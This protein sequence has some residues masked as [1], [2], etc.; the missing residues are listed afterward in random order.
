MNDHDPPTGPQF[1]ASRPTE[2]ESVRTTIVG[3]RPPGSGQ[4]LGNLCRGVEVLV[5]KASVDPAFKELLLKQ[6]AGAAAEI[7]LQLDPA[8]AAMLAAAT[9][10]QLEAV[11]ASVT[12]PEE[13]RRTFLGTVAAAMLAALGVA[14]VGGLVCPAGSRARHNSVKGIRPEQY[15]TKVGG[16]QPDRFP[17]KDVPP[18][19]SPP[20]EGGSSDQPL[21]SKPANSGESP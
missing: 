2:Q 7:G 17:P 20:N 15:P 18:E 3:G 21:P 1:D 19:E 9:P 10:E 4:P 8:E 16:I 12:V 14:V 5:K 11:I 13:H 6:R